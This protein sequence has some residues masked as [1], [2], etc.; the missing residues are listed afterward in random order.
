MPVPKPQQH[1]LP[2]GGAAVV[3]RPVK[4]QALP[5][6][7]I[8]KT[9]QFGNSTVHIADNAYRDKTPEEIEKVLE[10]YHAAGWRIIESLEKSELEKI[11]E[12]SEKEGEEN[13]YPS[14]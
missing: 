5:V 9:Y 10:D 8:V 7:N 14:D 2:I 11:Q 3:R 13:G 6:P 1:T 4:S 12:D